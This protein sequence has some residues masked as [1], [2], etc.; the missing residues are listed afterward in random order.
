MGTALKDFRKRPPPAPRCDDR[1]PTPWPLV[2]DEVC[3]RCWQRPAPLGDYPPVKTHPC[4][5][6]GT[7][8]VRTRAPVIRQAPATEDAWEF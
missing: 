6:E 8:A 1:C 4:F 5:W 3:R 2:D 7:R